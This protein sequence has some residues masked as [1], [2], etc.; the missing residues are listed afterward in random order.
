MSLIRI[1]TINTQGLQSSLNKLSNLIHSQHIHIAFLQETHHIK[2]QTIT[3]F[4]HTNNFEILTNTHEHEHDSTQ[5][6]QGTAIILN[7]T[8]LSKFKQAS[9][10]TQ[11]ILPKRIQILNFKL[12]SIKYVFINVYHTS[13]KSP[14]IRKNEIEIIQDHIKNLK[15]S[16][17]KIFI[18]GDF[19]FVLNKI[20]RT[21]LF[22][23]STIDKLYFSKLITQFNLTDAFRKLNPNLR[24]YT[25]IHSQHASRLDRIYIPLD[26]ISNIQT[27]NH[28]P[29]TFS[30]H[31]QAPTITIK[32]TEPNKHKSTYWKLNTSIL[33]SESNINCIKAFIEQLINRNMIKPN[34][35]TWWEKFKIKIKTYL[36]FI[37]RINSLNMNKQ[38][39]IL[40][41]QLQ[42]E[43][44]RRNYQEM[45]RINDQIA[46][47]QNYKRKGAQIRT[48][49]PPLLSI[50][51]PSP[52]SYAREEKKCLKQKLPT[53]T[54]Q[55]RNSP[56]TS[57]NFLTQI[58]TFFADIWS[59][60]DSLFEPSPYL[61]TLTSKIDS[62]LVDLLPESPLIT[63]DEIKSAVRCLNKHSAPGCDGLPT[64]FYTSFP[65]TYPLLAETFNNS[66][67]QSK[68]TESQMLAI[69]KLIPKIQSPKTVKD[70]RPIS[71]L[72]TDYKILSFIIANRLKP[73]LNSAISKSQQ[74]GLPKRQI[75]NC[76]LNI[77]TAIEYATETHQSL[78]IL[79]IDFYKAFDSI[80]HTFLLHTATSLG[81]PPSLIK[82]IKICL[83]NLSSKII[84]NNA[85]SEKI[86]IQRGIRQGCPLSMLLFIIAIQPLTEQILSNTQI[87]GLKIGKTSLVVNHYADDLTLF[88]TDPKSFTK[89]ESILRTFSSY[90]GLKTN[91]QKTKML[92]NSPVFKNAFKT[93]FP[94]GQD[95]NTSKILGLHFSFKPNL[96]EKN[97]L[98]LISQTVN[99]TT[100]LLNPNDS[101]YSK[102]IAINEHILPKILF[103]A[104]IFPPQ[105][106]QIKTINTSIFKYLWN[107][108]IIE[109][110]K[111]TTLYLPKDQGGISLP[112]IGVKAQTALAW[113]LIALL[114]S[115][116]HTSQFWMTHANF[117]LST[118]IKPFK[119][120]FYTNSQPHKPKPN[121]MWNKILIKISRIDTPP[122]QLHSVTFKNL[123]YK[124]LNQDPIPIPSTIKSTTPH[125]WLQIALFKPKSH[126]F[127]NFEKEIAF[128]TATNTF[129][130]GTFLCD[131]HFPISKPNKC[132]LCKQGSDDPSH[133]FVECPLTKEILEKMQDTIAHTTHQ[134]I[135]LTRNTMLYNQ[136]NSVGNT[137]IIIT[138][139]AS[140]IRT[141]LYI[142]RKRTISYNTTFNKKLQKETLFKIKVKFKDFINVFS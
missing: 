4:A 96:N 39:N 80:S 26:Q 93:S 60:Q 37:S 2:S 34:P 29:I 14:K 117:N 8:L 128:R 38:E 90:S 68:L 25:L 19:N 137:H 134:Q 31:K 126:L 116:D 102:V 138:K 51:E 73:L 72:N 114:Q 125:S 45:I 112:S 108:S 101:L 140:L 142:M 85:Q 6:R 69:V 42:A 111:R 99:L 55:D 48:R 36:I 129:A 28:I 30:D 130:W 124:F 139:A 104:R 89:I 86:P 12:S 3:N 122:N 53:Q 82:W 18:L 141:T 41:K 109:P 47:L 22:H 74:C 9:Y 136:T 16:T 84:L 62:K 103:V 56:N 106:K 24:Q 119:A 58:T 65:S 54:N 127:S 92:S 88:I 32:L 49:D 91:L 76:H 100:S 131:H 79:Q 98:N 135:S 35:L 94:Q 33:K 75:F 61:V 97:W 132:K 43:T 20:D 15:P 13:G 87:K 115:D 81:I 46:K 63:I 5:H 7:K 11:N 57:T 66:F 64:S 113:Q 107:D 44:N 23:P 1:V 52:H 120:S 77:K 10:D 70:W 105:P 78:A 17:T 123:Y 59:K 83:T 121:Q 40:K 50:D 110:I 21:G 118:K 95:Q 133:L 27:C 67:I 71:L